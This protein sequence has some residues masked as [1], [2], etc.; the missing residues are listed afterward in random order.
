MNVLAKSIFASFFVFWRRNCPWRFIL[1]LSFFLFFVVVPNASVGI[2]S[3][4]AYSA[5]PSS[6]PDPSSN[7]LCNFIQ[8]FTD[9]LIKSM[10]KISTDYFV[11]MEKSKSNIHMDLQ[12]T[13]GTQ[14]NLEKKTKEQ[15]QRSHVF[16]CQNLFWNYSNENNM[17]VQWLRLHTFTAKGLGLIPGPGT[18]IPNKPPDAAKNLNK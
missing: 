11:E 8:V 1:F 16:L 5:C 17:E 3:L 2:Q 10:I 7:E 9:W 4:L 12:R 14:N 15:R 6:Q 13:M 18:K